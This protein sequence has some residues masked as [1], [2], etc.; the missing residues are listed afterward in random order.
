MLS[1]IKRK[2]TILISNKADFK[3]RKVIGDKERHYLM[4]KKWIL[5]EDNNNL[6]CACA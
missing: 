1:L 5:Q 3:E 2:V 6:S 4:I